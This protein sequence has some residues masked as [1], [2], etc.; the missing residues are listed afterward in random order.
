MEIAKVIK[1]QG[2]TPVVEQIGDLQVWNRFQIVQI[3]AVNELLGTMFINK[4]I[5]G[6]FSMDHMT[7]PAHAG[8]VAIFGKVAEANV[9]TLLSREVHTDE[10]D[11]HATILLAKLILILAQMESP[12]V[13]VSSKVV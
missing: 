7:V 8:S 3:L 10:K 12:V 6:I 13:V 11:E 4:T 5:W 1:V 9:I 2:V